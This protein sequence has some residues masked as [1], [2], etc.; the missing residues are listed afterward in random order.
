MTMKINVTTTLFFFTAGGEICNFLTCLEASPRS[1]IFT[2]MG[3]CFKFFF[4][5]FGPK[6]FPTNR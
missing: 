3:G 5:K 2:L 6:L 4:F 1:S